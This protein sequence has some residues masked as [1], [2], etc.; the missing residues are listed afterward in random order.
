MS[1]FCNCILGVGRSPLYVHN[2]L[3]TWEFGLVGLFYLYLRRTSADV[4]RYGESFGSLIAVILFAFL[5]LCLVLPDMDVIHYRCL[6]ILYPFLHSAHA[7]T[8]L[9][10]SSIESTSF[11]PFS[12]QC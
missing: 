10:I 8:I 9:P 2:G 12:A 5:L 3:W 1:K 4:S 11:E 6:L 7:F